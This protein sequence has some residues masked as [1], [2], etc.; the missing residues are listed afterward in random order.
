MTMV[1]TGAPAPSLPNSA[2]DAGAPPTIDTLTHPSTLD[3]VRKRLRRPAGGHRRGRGRG[4]ERGRFLTRF[5]ELPTE[6]RARALSALD[7]ESLATAALASRALRADAQAASP[8]VCAACEVL[9]DR[10][11]RPFARAPLRPA[12]SPRLSRGSGRGGRDDG[13]GG[14]DGRISSRCGGAVADCDG[15]S[16][17]SGSGRGGSNDGGD[18][19]C[20]GTGAD[21]LALARATAR[22]LEGAAS[23]AA[24][25]PNY[26]R[27]ARAFSAAAARGHAPAQANLAFMVG[28]R[29]A[30]PPRWLT[31]ELLQE[32]RRAAAAAASPSRRATDD[33]D[34]GGGA[35]SGDDGDDDEW[36][37]ED[38]VGSA[39]LR[40]RA[41]N[42]L[43]RRAAVQG[44]AHAQASVAVAF[45]ERADVPP[46]AATSDDDDDE[47]AVAWC[48]SQSRL[49]SKAHAWYARAAVQGLA[50]GALGVRQVAV[51]RTAPRGG[52]PHRDALAQLD[53]WRHEQQAAAAAQRRR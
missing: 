46:P 48:R 16:R 29:R 26:T 30:A 47:A 42:E 6:L 17:R 49:L 15:D 35:R 3:L 40:R 45:H 50:D 53:A 36:S 41:E 1:W 4:R 27:A 21:W 19:N 28:A 20:G 38:A 25:K 14:D 9:F 23:L 44:H 8:A 52:A 12:R 11:D 18:G 5:A 22:F 13:G 33:D 51:L 2:M 34:D 37:D 43:W 31:R 24:A 10:F 32:W 7:G 39:A